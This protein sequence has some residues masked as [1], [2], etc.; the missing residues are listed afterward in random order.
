MYILGIIVGVL[1]VSFFMSR[2]IGTFIAAGNP[3]DDEM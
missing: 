3:K 1:I 2:Y